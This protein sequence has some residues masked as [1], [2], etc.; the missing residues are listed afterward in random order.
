MFLSELLASSLRMAVPILLTALGA[1]FTERAGVVNIGLEGMMIVG[2][3]WGALGSYYYGPYF[4]LLLAMAAGMFLALIHAVNTVTFRVDQIVSGVAINILAY[5][6]CRFLSQAI[7]KMATTSP[8][9]AGLPKIDIPV[10]AGIEFLKPL[11]SGV[12]P[13]IILALLLVPLTRFVINRTV[14]GLRLRSVGE[15]PLAAD[16]LGINVFRMKYAGVLLSGMLAGLSGAYLALE[17]TGMYVE[18][19]TQGQGFIALA[20]MIFGNWEPAGALWAALLFGFSEALSFRVVE[21]GAIPY[22]FIKMIPYVLT[23]AVLAGVVRK[24]TPPAADGI[25]Y[26]RGMK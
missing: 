8:H 7:F 19:M 10:L 24:S 4:G 5:G 14:F 11:V 12:S 15:N 20:A 13:I 9:V 2:S 17:H 26:E 22:Q 25:P 16:T 3:F 18:G 21:G 1:V 6:S 23:L